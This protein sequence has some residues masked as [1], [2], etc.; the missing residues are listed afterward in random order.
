[1]ALD[2]SPYPATPTNHRWG[3]NPLHHPPDY[4]VVSANKAI[5]SCWRAGDLD[6]ARHLFDSMPVRTAASWNT[7]ITGYSKSDML[8]QALTLFSTMLRSNVSP[9]ET[10]FSLSLSVCGRVGSL[11]GGRQ[12]HGLVVKSGHVKFKHVG[13][14]LLHAYA[15][16]SRIWDARVVF[17]ELI[18]DNELLWSPMLAGFVDCGLMG[19]ACNVF[20]KMPKRGVVE[21]TTLISGYAKSDNGFEKALELFNM[22]RESMIHDGPNEFT[23]DCLVRGC[24]ESGD[25]STGRALHGLVVKSG[26]ER[27]HSVCGALVCLY[28]RYESMDEA[29]TVCNSVSGLALGNMNE[30]IGGFV[31][32]GKIEKAESIFFGMPKKNP[33][34]YNIMIKGYASC[35]RFEDAERL[36]MQMPVK[37]L[38]SLNTMIMAYAKNGE[39]KKAVYLF[40]KAKNEKSPITWNSIITGHILN[41]GHEDAFRL[42]LAMCRSSIPRTRSTFS[43]LFHSCACTGS[44]QQGRLLHAHLSKTPFSSNVF[45]GT[46][47]IDMYSKCGSM[48]DAHTAFT[49]ISSPNVA[50]WTALIN[51]LAHHRPSPEVLLLF[52]LMMESGV[53]PNAAT[54][55]AVLSACARSGSVG[56]GLRLFRSMTEDHG[57]KPALEHLTCVV[58]LLGRAGLLHE[59]EELVESTEIKADGYLLISLL[60]AS[61]HWM[62]MGLAERVERRMVEMGL[63]QSASAYVIVS[64]MYSGLGKWEKKKAVRDTLRDLGGKKDPG[65]SWV[66]VNNRT[67]VF[68]VD[69]RENPQSDVIYANL[70]SLS[71]NGYYSND[72]DSFSLFS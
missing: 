55:V 42:Y 60:H 48:S 61:W 11:S 10:T 37:T 66:D 35:S 67:H 30:L 39:L 28:S 1:M 31:N 62:D 51:G 12:V 24:S 16:C 7:I 6:G 53:A 21:W 19:Q 9:N 43:I 13:S 65:W 70:E 4:D 36:F 25:L 33:V 27:E 2:P 64:N 52:R 50:A 56:P 44:L 46:S 40:D 49:S 34:T 68:S 54:F 14:S 72:F 47:L 26:L 63:S 69:C 57:I 17:D 71:V 20:D 3:L 23:L 58:D 41:D 45:V 38:S 29:Q 22:M 59:A 5:T 15:S 18:E 8:Q 32:L